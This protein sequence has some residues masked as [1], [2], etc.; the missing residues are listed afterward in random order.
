MSVDVK[1]LL[2]IELEEEQEDTGCPKREKTALSYEAT[3]DGINLV[4]TK[5]LSKSVQRAI[6]SV[7]T[8]EFRMTESTILKDGSEG[9]VK[10]SL[11]TEKAY[12]SFM[13]NLK[14]F[15]SIEVKGCRYMQ[16][17]CNYSYNY[18]YHV[19]ISQDFYDLVS[20][21]AEK[22]ITVY[23]TP[24]MAAIDSSAWGCLRNFYP[25]LPLLKYI[26]ETYPGWYES[27]NLYKTEAMCVLEEAFGMEAAKVWIKDA[28]GS[29]MNL[30]GEVRRGMHSETRCILKSL[31]EKYGMRAVSGYIQ[32]N[33]PRQGIVNF[34]ISSN[35]DY[36]KRSQNGAYV[37]FLSNQIEMYDRIV[38]PFPLHFLEA[39][40][41]ANLIFS[42]WESAVKKKL[43]GDES[44]GAVAKAF[45][46]SM[47]E[48]SSGRCR[49]R[50]PRTT[51]M[52]A[53][54]CC[55]SAIDLG[56]TLEL[57]CSGSHFLFVQEKT[58][59]VSVRFDGEWNMKE[60]HNG[61]SSSPVSAELLDEVSGWALSVRDSENA[62]KAKDKKTA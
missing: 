2:N 1:E 27:R 60:A 34:N 62:E 59:C 14:R 44:D 45:P 17:I 29:Y 42:G 38:D 30:T 37:R 22:L 10:A 15:S 40:A 54:L 47:E 26:S 8:R 35:P 19:L 51:A 57:I 56:E 36:E 48:A 43:N 6:F 24:S 52:L 46:G 61:A 7:T 11:M 55:D 28:C 32:K 41:K 58:G 5:R 16:R 18:V 12:D 50:I 49:F 25:H 13:R 3:S 23:S 21:G 31:S 39:I 20:I 4:I 9:S 33:L 53:K